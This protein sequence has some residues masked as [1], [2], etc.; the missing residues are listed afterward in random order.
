M[1]SGETHTSQGH[2]PSTSRS[3][4]DTTALGSLAYAS[5][6]GSNGPLE[7]GTAS[8]HL[9]STAEQGGST[10]NDTASSRPANGFLPPRPDGRSTG[11]ENPNQAYNSQHPHTTSLAASAVAQAR[12]QLQGQPQTSTAT[13]SA[14]HPSKSVT[15]VEQSPQSRPSSTQS[16]RESD[17]NRL[18]HRSY[19]SPVDQNHNQSSFQPPVNNSQQAYH[20]HRMTAVDD[21][22]KESKSRTANNTIS[23]HRETSNHSPVLQSSYRGNG[24]QAQNGQPTRGRPIKYAVETSNTQRVEREARTG[25]VSPPVPE[26]SL[27]TVNPNQVFNQQEYQKRKAA[28]EA[29]AQAAKKAAQTTSQLPLNTQS[30]KTDP[31]NK[32]KEKREGEIKSLLG[33]IFGYMREMKA[34]DPEMFLQ[35][36]EEFK[37]VYQL[38]SSVND[39]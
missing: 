10:T 37:K 7:Q 14:S 11:Y 33:S 31:K 26:D 30:S 34:K 32:D 18:Y 17:S 2:V 38:H 19:N 36:W 4:I 35:V 6:L 3:Y 27:R 23:N 1:G 24:A 5:A 39:T 8:R 21:A 9:P 22:N 25:L 16:H 15:T 13:S 20:S 28:A 12:R 29:E